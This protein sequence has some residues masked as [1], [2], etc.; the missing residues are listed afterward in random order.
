MNHNQSRSKCPQC[1]TTIPEDAPES[2]CPKCLMAN[3]GVGS[4]KSSTQHQGMTPPSLEELAKVFPELEIIELIGQGGMGFVFKVR[5]PKLDRIVALKLLP[6]NLSRDPHFAERFN[7]EARVLAKLSHPN[8]VAVFESGHRNPYYFFLM[9]YVDGLN[10]REAMQ[11]GRFSPKEA[12]KLVPQICEALQFAHDQK[13]LH[14]DI[15]PENI[16]LNEKGKIKIADFGIAKIA[17]QSDSQEITLT[18]TG[19][20]MGSPHYMAPEQFENPGEIDHRADI[21]SLGVVFYELL[22]GELPIGRFDPPSF[23]VPM[24]QT[25]DRIVLRALEKDRERR[26]KSAN[27]L[28]TEVDTVFSNQA[29]VSHK[30]VTRRPSSIS[31][32]GIMIASSVMT[33]L[34]LLA[35]VILMGLL[36]TKG[37][38]MNSGLLL[39]LPVILCGVPGTVLGWIAL[40]KIRNKDVPLEWKGMALLG[41]SGLLILLFLGVL[42]PFSLNHDE[43]AEGLSPFGWGTFTLLVLF[44]SFAYFRTVTRWLRSAKLFSWIE[45]I[46]LV[47]LILLIVSFVWPIRQSGESARKVVMTRSRSSQ[48]A[49]VFQFDQIAPEYR[50]QDNSIDVVAIS[51]HPSSGRWWLPDGSSW[52]QDPFINPGFLMGAQNGY[53]SVEIVARVRGANPQISFQAANAGNLAGGNDRLKSSPNESGEY[54]FIAEFPKGLDETTL[55]IGATIGPWETFLET[56]QLA[57]AT[58]VQSVSWWSEILKVE[59]KGWSTNSADSLALLC[60]HNL[61]NIPCRVIA[62]DNSGAEHFGKLTQSK[63]GS[64][65][66]FVFQNIQVKQIDRL[67]FQVLPYRWK[68]VEQVHLKP[69]MNLSDSQNGAPTRMETEIVFSGVDLIS[70]GRRQKLSIE[71]MLNDQGRIPDWTTSADQEDDLIQIETFTEF[72]DTK[73]EADNSTLIRKMQVLLPIDLS[74]KELLKLLQITQQ[75]WKSRSLSLYPGDGHEILSIPSKGTEPIS[76]SISLKE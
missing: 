47:L 60:T 13:V 10:L 38:S 9:E 26:Q 23:N 7:R 56:D 24:D 64:T 41:S 39:S 67:K 65:A 42:I 76:V 2:L 66:E 20:R 19:L 25:I 36:V 14:R 63:V 48:G 32:S 33:T 3:L 31:G 15:K 29:S 21:Y 12:L 71:Y 45:I 68:K 16:L 18:Q 72:S 35:A 44:V 54:L 5:Q 11:A 51:A 49:G 28:K 6:E 46:I 74:D 53:R 17:G 8:I 22:T 34:S 55:N 30:G 27:E 40:L 50:I 61:N 57:I 59:L 1:G 58:Q 43:G 4:S 75:T 52:D 73:G 70:A 62:V 69:N 37:L